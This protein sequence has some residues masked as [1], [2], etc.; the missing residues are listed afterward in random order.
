MSN[1]TITVLCENEGWKTRFKPH[2]KNVR[3]AC[4]AAIPAGKKN[5]ELTVVLADDAFIRELNKT[6]RGKNKPTNVLSFVGSR[7]HLGDV[8]LA[9][10]TI[11]KEAA[12]QKKT[13]KGH[14]THLLVH[15]TLH[16]LGHDHENESDAETM[17]ALEIKILKKLGVAN[18]YL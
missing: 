6:Y 13:F 3:I 18:P 17:E 7:E 14:A 11:Q 12:M 16:L 15:G 1:V 4:E 8:V 9:L 2:V 5:R 10:E